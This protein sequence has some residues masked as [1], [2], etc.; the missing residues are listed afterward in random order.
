MK[1]TEISDK[2]FED[3]YNQARLDMAG[4]PYGEDLENAARAAA[5]FVAAQAHAD[6]NWAVYKKDRELLPPELKEAFTEIPDVMAMVPT[7]PAMPEDEFCRQKA[8]LALL[9]T[10]KQAG[11]HIALL[12]AALKV[13]QREFAQ[14]IGEY[15]GL[16]I[17]PQ[18][19]CRIEKGARSASTQ[20]LSAI[21]VTLE[22]L[23]HSSGAL[24]Y[25]A[26]GQIRQILEGQYPGKKIFV[27]PE[28]ELTR[29]RTQISQFAQPRQGGA[30]IQLFRE[31]FGFTRRT[32]IAEMGKKGCILS[33][34]ELFDIEKG[35]KRPSRRSLTGIVAVL[36]DGCA[37]TDSRG[38][39]C[40]PE[41]LL[42]ILTQGFADIPLIVVSGTEEFTTR[43]T[44]AG[45][46]QDPR[47]LLELVLRELNWTFADLEK[48]AHLS[49][50]RVGKALRGERFLSGQEL[51]CITHTLITGL[52]SYGKRAEEEL[53]RNMAVCFQGREPFSGLLRTDGVRVI[54]SCQGKEIARQQDP[55][56]FDQL[57]ACLKSRKKIW[58]GGLFVQAQA[59]T[60]SRLGFNFSKN[61]H[62]GLHTVR[63]PVQYARRPSAVLLSY[64][65]RLGLVYMEEF[66]IQG[67]QAQGL[68]MLRRRLKRAEVRALQTSAAG[69]GYCR[70]AVIAVAGT[71][72]GAP[73]EK[74][75]FNISRRVEML[76]RDTPFEIVIP[77]LECRRY[78][79]SAR[80]KYSPWVLAMGSNETVY[81]PRSLAIRDW[82]VDWRQRGSIPMEAVYRRQGSDDVYALDELRIVKCASGKPQNKL[83][84][85]LKSYKVQ[86]ISERTLVAYDPGF[87]AILPAITQKARQLMNIFSPLEVLDILLEDTSI[88]QELRTPE[89]MISV[90]NIQMR[91][92]TLRSKNYPHWKALCAAWR[93]KGLGELDLVGLYQLCG[94]A[95]NLLRQFLTEKLRMPLVVYLP[96]KPARFADFIRRLE[97]PLDRVLER[98]DEMA[99]CQEATQELERLRKIDPQLVDAAQKLRQETRGIFALEAARLIG[100]VGAVGAGK[101]SSGDFSLPWFK[102][103]GYMQD[104]PEGPE[105]GEPASAEFLAAEA[106]VT[107]LHA[108]AIVCGAQR[109][110][111]L[112]KQFSPR[113]LKDK[114]AYCQLR[115]AFI[116]EINAFIRRTL[117]PQNFLE[118]WD[119]WVAA[120]CK[121]VEESLIAWEDSGSMSLIVFVRRELRRHIGREVWVQMEKR[122]GSG[123]SPKDP[124]SLD[125]LLSQDSNADSYLFERA[126]EQ[127]EPDFRFKKRY[128]SLH[129]FG[130]FMETE[131]FSGFCGNDAISP[132]TKLQIA[133][134]LGH[135]LE[136][137]GLREKV[138][139]LGVRSLAMYMVWDSGL[140]NMAYLNRHTLKLLVVTD[141]LMEEGISGLA[142]G[143]AGMLGARVK[144]DADRWPWPVI[145]LANTNNGDGNGF[146]Q[147]LK[148]S[149]VGTKRELARIG[150]VNVRPGGGGR[151]F[152]GWLVQPG[153]HDIL[154]W[155]NQRGIGDGLA[156]AIDIRKQEAL[157]PESSDTRDKN[158][159]PGVF[160]IGAVWDN[161]VKGFIP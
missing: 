107:A 105:A 15:A 74:D 24:H 109:E 37:K 76:G 33:E 147:I 102:D 41:E 143:I 65:A 87:A 36:E 80:D 40:K 14:L 62:N 8:A 88:P 78:Q 63:L 141:E 96:L 45:E 51:A 133:C 21:A 42:G 18:S 128:S 124:V 110:F 106:G 73:G 26:N 150:I 35:I 149:G 1:F 89:T 159:A 71:F 75:W 161:A 111:L 121:I 31:L 101:R 117:G 82:P 61:P 145:T 67:D 95:E 50:D 27:S 135:W 3:E 60:F 10:E 79:R 4:S 114:G 9:P 152:S 108:E 127:Y 134:A 39:L 70:Q 12:R 148:D 6:Y 132:L 77:E 86:R 153:H 85:V 119:Y 19:L 81:F 129:A 11:A 94:H 137:H 120:A 2:I 156:N 160:S 83:C 90:L 146:A 142:E 116:G 103:T 144:R 34:D 69:D 126:P 68:P 99:A 84:I 23:A 56:T 97:S 66:L 49:K 122:K 47:V 125:K 38:Q 131:E 157:I 113:H 43:I 100:A 112:T 58:L 17:K 59:S 7:A 22:S 130:S 52:A 54:F 151:L 118:Y 123:W 104:F 30:Y 5:I 28:E 48:K 139:A 115:A 16:K 92:F 64:D 46:K 140:L 57:Y 44:Q 55:F 154:V 138:N 155:E 32:F 98:L 13:G 136:E 72:F 91:G 158:S 93:A 29:R 53:S 20:A 25:L